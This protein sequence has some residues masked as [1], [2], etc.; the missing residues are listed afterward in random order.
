MITDFFIK[1]SSLFVY[2]TL[3]VFIS[4]VLTY[5]CIYLLPAL[6][7]IDKPG[8]RHI[9]KKIV[10]RGGGIA[11][12]IAFFS[13]LAFYILAHPGDP[14]NTHLFWQL[15]WPALILGGL[16]LIDDRWELPSWLKLI[17][18]FWVILIIWYNG[19]DSYSIFGWVMPSLLSFLFLSV[20]IIVFINAFNLIDGLDGLASGLAIVSSFCMVL[21]F[22]MTGE[23]LIASV[24][25]LI[26]AGSCLG[27]LRYNFHPAKIF[28]GDT[29]ST[30]LGLVFAVIGL[31]AMDRI[32]T[33][34]S[35]LLPVLA[36]G[37][38]LFDVV[39]A[40]WRRST[41]KLL[42]P[43][44]GGIMDGDQDHLHHRLFRKTQKQTTTAFV[45][46]LIGC[47]FAIV[48]LLF[49]GL[50]DS[51]PAI[52]YIILLIMI[53]VLIR[54]LAV[55]EL[56]DSAML[57]KRGLSRPRKSLL[58]NMV[59]PFIDLFM[60][61]VSYT[62]SLVLLIGYFQ[63]LTLY[64]Y[65][66]VPIFLVLLSSRMYRIYWLRAG[67]NN[68][69]HLVLAI[70]L[71]SLL[72]CCIIT[73]TY[74]KTFAGNFGISGNVFLALCLLFT[75]LNVILIA[76]ERFLLHYVEAFWLRK[77]Y[78]QHNDREDVERILIYGGGLNCRLYI[79]YLF[80]S[81]SKERPAVVVGLLDD[82]PAL[83]G[84]RVYGF[85]VYGGLENLENL[86]SKKKFNKVI[87][88]IDPLTPDKIEYLHNFCSQREI[89]IS[90]LNI[91]ENKITLP[92]QS[93]GSENA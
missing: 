46:Y 93:A 1:Y 72:S 80:C 83:H 67:L 58:V 66:I 55:V 77:V 47:A 26:L 33:I 78:Y 6:G 52:A 32:V 56:L 86:H 73:L 84:L 37:V 60:I 25:M 31:S 51:S 85:K 20:W 14:G 4:L 17:V 12:I 90:Q 91:N 49:L 76:S 89:S 62:L 43:G 30:F 39:L 9:H 50:S 22:L 59:H 42:N 74:Y 23:P 79:N 57:I 44:A 63:D 8:G 18:Q 35:L 38:P 2:P 45:M 68:Y 61:T 70:F 29:G 65:A 87:I 82:D 13:A 92:N 36:I 10:P 69:W 11:V 40:I 24:T 27:F 21:W 53:L 15:F 28:L 5:L 81:H 54:Q 88:A 48:A 3:A 19:P 41:R 16:G 71:G 75:V 7:Y 64:L 34:T